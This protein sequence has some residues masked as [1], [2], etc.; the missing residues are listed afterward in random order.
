MAVLIVPPI[1][2]DE[3][4]IW[5]TLGDQVAEWIEEHA[6]WGPGSKFGQPVALDDEFHAW[7]LRAYQIFPHGHPREGRRRFDLCALEMAKGTGKTERALVVAQ[8]ELHPSAPVRC[9][10]FKHV[11]RAWKP[12]GKPVPYPK[13][14]FVASSEEQVQRTAFGRFREALKKSPLA[15]DYHITQ[16][17]I[18][19]LGDD[20]ASA[21]E[22]YPVAV[23]PGTADGDL[24][25]FQHVDEP[26]RWDLPRHHEMFD[27]I[28]ENALKDVDADS[29]M[30]TSSTAGLTGDDSVEERLL[31][32]AE[33]IERGE[34]DQ[35]GM[36]FMRRHCPDTDDFPLDTFETV[37]IA[38]REARGPAASWSGDIPKI[39][40]KF[41]DPKT[42]RSYWE[43]VWLNRWVKGGGR[44]FD[45]T[46]W[47]GLSRP[48]EIAKGA[49]VTVGFD[50]ARHRDATGIVVTEIA[51]G[52]QQV[53]GVWERPYGVDE[54]EVPSLDVDAVMSEAFER[55]DVWR[56]YLDPPYWDDW[57]SVW[58]GRWGA[59]RAI[60]WYT[61]RDRPMAHALRKYAAAMTG[62]I[63]THDGNEVYARHVA[64]AIRKNLPARDEQDLQFWVIRKER[65]DS[66]DKIDLAMAGCLSWEARSDAISADAK[67]K[68]R[69]KTASF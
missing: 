46:T 47:A 55:F 6:V 60:K 63:L 52:Y 32:S 4:K 23:S 58:E 59:D 49:F 36:F 2:S 15:G 7:L 66:P 56:A 57:I 40:A 27:T 68:R 43:R 29:W 48:H 33:A 26:H 38:V 14:V 62:K 12:Q 31:H 65:A 30:M 67:P 41:F 28:G 34:V 24:P 44:A 61:N 8:A 51:T 53:M 22:A 5:A 42:D 17:K 20:G 21:G 16:D 13:L 50:G 45:A 25:T 69:F 39:V 3:Q 54:W 9:A 11:G 18:V 35:P 19:L 10:G 37:E 1:T 64:N